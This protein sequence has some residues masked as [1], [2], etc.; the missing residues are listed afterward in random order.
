MS[1]LY[2]FI[3]IAVV[4]LILSFLSGCGGTST[5]KHKTSEPVSQTVSKSA[6]AEMSH[7][8]K[9]AYAEQL[10]ES[11][12]ST[13]TLQKNQLL[14]K[15]LSI[16]TQVLSAAELSTEQLDYTQQLSAKIISQLELEML[17]TEQNN[18]YQ[19]ALAAINLKNFQA[20]KTLDILNSVHFN[21]PEQLAAAHKIRAMA[22]FQL[23]QKVN[24]IKELIVRQDYL[25]TDAQKRNNLNLIWRYV[26]SLSSYDTSSTAE[27]QD[28]LSNN[29]RI[30]KGWLEL[31]A[32]LRDSHDPDTLNHAINFWLQSYPGHPADRAFIQAILQA[33]QNA[34]L[35]IHHIAV[36]LP[37]QGKLA[38]PALAIRDGIL[39]SH[40]HSPIS[41]DLELRFYDTSNDDHIWLTYQ[42]A[43]DNG[44]DFIIGPLAKSN[45][46]VLAESSELN[47]PTLA[48]NS[49]ENTSAMSTTTGIKNLFQFGLSPEAE[50]RHVARK[51]RLDGH[52]YAA[53]IA[54]QNHW[55]KRMQSAFSQQWQQSGGVIV[56]T[57]AYDPQA[58]DYSATIKSLLN[59]DQSEARKKQLSRTINRKVEFTPR[60]RQDIDML[61][62]AAFPRQAKQ[63]PLQIIYHHGETIPIYS[64]AH[65]VSNYHSPKQN[66]DMDGVLFSDMPFLLGAKPDAVSLQSSSYQNTLYKRLFAM[67][68]DSYQ[69]APYVRFLQTNAAESFAGDTG[70]LTI[71][72][73]GHII[74]TM[75]WATFKQGNIMRL[76]SN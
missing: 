34:I 25:D 64:T 59:I 2:Q 44:A 75:P 29:E 56:D 20:S 40:Y 71:E 15:A 73:D 5:T 8:Q 22:L 48:L 14:I 76:N 31:A 72:P 49:L 37:L 35:N 43:I 27:Q 54:P 57:A 10:F 39:A 38:K 4:I 47:V 28:S 11:A 17:T 16:C 42:K 69:L 12:L 67:G 18:R 58:Q 62:M 50:A 46:E 53:I 7:T 60:R 45:L 9:L 55:G 74:R 51:G 21:S 24:A 6:I 23:D 26:G 68:V 61:F 19:L 65:I 13:Q 66:I 52:Y 41:N 33:R 1:R 30:Y 32:I 63:I 70:Q 3:S 36:L